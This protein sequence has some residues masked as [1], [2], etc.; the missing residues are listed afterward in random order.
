MWKISLEILTPTSCD[1]YVQ[2][3]FFLFFLFLHLNLLDPKF[4]FILF[5]LCKVFSHFSLD[6]GNIVRFSMCLNW[7]KPTSDFSLVEVVS[8]AHTLLTVCP[9]FRTV[10]VTKMRFILISICVWRHDEDESLCWS[11]GQWGFQCLP[12]TVWF[13]VSSDPQYFTVLGLPGLYSLTQLYTQIIYLIVENIYEYIKL[14]FHFNYFKC[15][16]QRH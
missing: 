8:S 9:C 4:Y 1:L 11:Q 7:H 2:D 3:I 5:A 13:S 16:I 12:H 10:I 14:K 6:F 15:T